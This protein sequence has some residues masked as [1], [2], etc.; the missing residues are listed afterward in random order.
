MSTVLDTVIGAVTGVLS[1]MGVGGGSLLMLYLTLFSD[2]TQRTAQG[3]NLLYFLP[4]AG[5][6]LVGHVKQKLIETRAFFWSGGF[7]VLACILSS[8]L[9]GGLSA[10]L[11]R[12]GFGLFILIVG[13]TELVRRK[14]S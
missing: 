2:V 9:A 12:R 1:G 11:L 3:I 6:S 4:T 10:P 8:R 7:G 14:S 5:S 13:L